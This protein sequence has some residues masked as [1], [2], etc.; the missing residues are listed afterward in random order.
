MQ[1]Q[2]ATAIHAVPVRE[3][4]RGFRLLVMRQLHAAT[5]PPGFALIEQHLM[6]TPERRGRHSVFFA[7]AF[8]PEI[9]AWL[10]ECLGRAASRDVQG[11]PQRNPRWPVTTWHAEER[12]WPDGTRSTEWHIDVAFP[13]EASWIAFSQQWR[14]R[15]EGR[16]EEG[17]PGAS[18]EPPQA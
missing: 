16:R 10:G 9:M 5:E 8:L 13:D 1:H 4:P 18:V 15:L 14:Q 3:I 7:R 11:L 6:R 17:A 2:E 12:L